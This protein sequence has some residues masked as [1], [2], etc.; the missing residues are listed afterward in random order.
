MDNRHKLALPYW[1]R[2]GISL[3]AKKVDDEDEGGNEVDEDDDDE[4]DE[5]DEDEDDLGELTEDELRAELK[6]T[7]QS[8]ST[9][10]GSAKVKRDKIKKLNAELAEARKPKPPAKRTGATDDDEKPDVEAIKDAAKAE[11]RA[12]SDGRIRKLAV[13]AELKAAGI[14]A[15]QA[16]R[17]IGLVDLDALDVDDDGEVEGLDEAIDELKAAWP[18]LFNVKPIRRARKSVAGGGDDKPPRGKLSPSQIQAARATGKR[19][20]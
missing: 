13:R 20:G 3:F 19:A 5:D 8:L 1:A 17:L 11:A 4:D 10:S 18:Q 12:E 9:A 15:D 6:K 14:P 2:P 16:G 7:R